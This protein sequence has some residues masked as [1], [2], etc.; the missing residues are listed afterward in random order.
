MST[1]RDAGPCINGH[2]IEQG[3]R[4]RSQEI[5]TACESYI[6][7][8][9]SSAMRLSNPRP[10]AMTH[11]SEAH[12]FDADGNEYIDWLCG[13]GPLIFGHRP[14]FVQEAMVD[15]LQ[16]RGSNCPFPSELAAEV[17]R[18]IVDAV[19]S[20]DS[21]RFANSGSEASQAVMRLARAYTG[22]DKILKFEGCY[23]GFLDCQALS[24]HPPLETAGP[25]SAPT[26][27]RFKWGV[28]RVLEETVLMGTYNDFEGVEKLVQQHSHELA[29]V[30]CEPVMSNAG[31]IPPDDG[32]LQ[33]LRDI[34]TRH[35]ILLIFDEV[36]TGFRLSL[37]G[38]QGLYAVQP[39]LTCFAKAIG[40]G[41]PG[42]AAFGGR[43]EVMELEAGGKVFHGG[44][45]AGNPMT[46]AGMKATLS[47]LSRSE[48]FYPRVTAIADAM[49]TGLR[50]V[51][52][53]RGVAACVNQVGGIWSVYFGHAEPVRRYRQARASDMDFY[54]EWQ[55]ECQSRGVF[56]HDNPLEN[57]FSCAAH[58][59]DDVRRSLEVIDHATEVVLRRGLP[60][61]D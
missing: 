21:V 30:M 15:E 7:G 41:T 46:L 59:P 14:A 40:G 53:K 4:K 36:I 28:P 38:A 25:E 8:G 6:A 48:D 55:V 54:K 11:G 33:H 43:A 3:D 32:W 42:A 49:V 9:D 51:F 44:T 31:V 2:V 61:A 20:I 17:A 19:P 56:F 57:W 50:E 45:Y 47:F 35:G 60:A 10:V 18:L 12:L 23:H 13:Y 26:P 24:T 22:K 52:S 5:L 1:V 58:T 34:T 37:A 29:A 27:V 39:D 16:R